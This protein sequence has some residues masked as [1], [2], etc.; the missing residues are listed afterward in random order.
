MCEDASEIPGTLLSSQSWP[1]VLCEDVHTYVLCPTHSLLCYA[2]ICCTCLFIRAV[3]VSHLLSATCQDDPSF[4][5]RRAY[6][7]KHNVSYTAYC[8]MH[9]CVVHVCSSVLS[10]CLTFCQQPAKMTHLS[11]GGEPVL[12]IICVHSLLCYKSAS[13]SS[14]NDTNYIM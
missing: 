6:C 4:G 12:S 9:A 2:R 3:K 5:R 8:V 13:S 10:R 7:V 14:P 1:Y 11:A